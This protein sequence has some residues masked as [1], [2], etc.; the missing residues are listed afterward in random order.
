MHPWWRLSSTS[1]ETTQ[2]GSVAVL[3]GSIVFFLRRKPIH[4]PLL[5]IDFLRRK[6]LIYV[7]RQKVRCPIPTK[8]WAIAAADGDVRALAAAYP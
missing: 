4:H 3:V 5:C 7:T 1:I 8:K 6:P 2:T